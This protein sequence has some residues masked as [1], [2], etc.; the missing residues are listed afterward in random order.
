MID[1]LRDYPEDKELLGRKSAKARKEVAAKQAA[2][3]TATSKMKKDIIIP[4]EKDPAMVTALLKLV[5]KTSKVSK[6][7]TE[8]TL[9]REY[10]DEDTEDILVVE[11]EETSIVYCEIRIVLF[12]KLPL[13]CSKKLFTI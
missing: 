10:K 7:L 11:K 1:A 6:L 2:N 9:E 12:T 5:P 8:G 13:K 3:T 4:L